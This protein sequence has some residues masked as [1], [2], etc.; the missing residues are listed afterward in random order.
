MG[1]VMLNDKQ[2]QETKA[3]IEK[4]DIRLD[5]L[6]RGFDEAR[7]DI[8]ECEEKIKNNNIDSEKH[9]SQ[10]RTLNMKCEEIKTEHSPLI[11][12]V[13]EQNEALATDEF[14]KKVQK[15]VN[16]AT[17]FYV[18][19]KT[20]LNR[21]Q[22]EYKETMAD[23]FH[24]VE[25]DIVIGFIEK[26]IDGFNDFS[27]VTLNYRNAKHSYEQRLKRLGT[28]KVKGDK[29]SFED[30]KQQLLRLDAF[31]ESEDVIHLWH[32]QL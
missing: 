2:V 20:R 31:L 1:Y 25:P 16:N 29:P 8:A 18:A 32:R 10:I 14:D 21:L 5:E 4:T 19:L 3:L 22:A 9:T 12:L 6:T 17:P 13:R 27:Q 24:F 30:A 11:H 26:R 7:K 15:V 28:A 23:L